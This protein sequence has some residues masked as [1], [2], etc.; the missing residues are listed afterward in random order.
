[1]RPSSLGRTGGQHAV[2]ICTRSYTALP[3]EH[4]YNRRLDRLGARHSRR[5]T[6]CQG[7]RLSVEFL[8]ELTAS[9]AAQADILAAYPQLTADGLAAAFLYAAH[10]LKHEQ[11]I[12]VELPA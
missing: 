11:T 1:M 10:A 8:L 5:Q 7:H 4:G 3:Y 12:D 6:L 9:G 2:A